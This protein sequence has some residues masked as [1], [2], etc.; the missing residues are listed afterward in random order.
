M[1]DATILAASDISVMF[2]DINAAGAAAQKTYY[3]QKLA[4]EEL[5]SKLQD[6]GENGARSFGSIAAAQ[7]FVNGQARAAL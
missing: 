2:A 1:Q 5:E 3:E 4:A 7:Q 6:L